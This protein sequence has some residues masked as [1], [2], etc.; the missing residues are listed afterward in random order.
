[1]IVASERSQVEEVKVE[2]SRNRIIRGE[3]FSWFIASERVSNTSV[4]DIC[5]AEN[6]IEGAICNIKILSILFS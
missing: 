5:F 1:M 6:V 3:D 2:V 4:W